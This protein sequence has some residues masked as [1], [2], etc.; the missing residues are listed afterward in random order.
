MTR[1]ASWRSV[2]LAVLLVGATLAGSVGTASAADGGP[3]THAFDME[4]STL[5]IDTGSYEGQVDIQIKSDEV[6][7]DSDIIYAGTVSTANNGNNRV[8]LV[9]GGAYDSITVIVS[10][11]PERPTFSQEGD[12]IARKAIEIGHTGGDADKQC[13]PAERTRAGLGVK[14]LDCIGYPGISSINTSSTDANQT[15]IDIYEDGLDTKTHRD[16]QLTLLENYLQD[17]Q[18]EALNIGNRAYV[19]ALRNGSSEAE[20]KTR[21]E[22]AIEDYYA[23]KQLQLR[24]SWNDSVADWAYS[25]ETAENETGISDS[26]LQVQYSPNGY[27][28]GPNITKASEMY[29]Y[30]GTM[31][32]VNGTDVPVQVFDAGGSKQAAVVPDP[33][34]ETGSDPGKYVEYFRIEAPNSEYDRLEYMNSSRYHALWTEIESQ[35][36]SVEREVNTLI[37]NSYTEYQNGEVD[38]DAFITPSLSESQYSPGDDY[39]AWAMSVLSQSGVDGPDSLDQIGSFTI[40]TN[41]TEYEG[42]LF[43]DSNPSSGRFENGATYNPAN[44]S[45]TQ[46]V[47]TEETTHILND[48]FTISEITDKD[49]NTVQNTSIET[50]TY[51]VSNLTQLQEEWDQLAQRRAEIEAREQALEANSGIPSSDGGGPD[52]QQYLLLI[53]GGAVAL[54]VVLNFA[55][56]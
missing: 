52:T 35:S 17:T 11:P 20:A 5:L 37:N 54:I 31:T 45:G 7:G 6:P 32:L 26:F 44:I 43:S 18:T 34:S 24:K 25:V 3:Y 28:P 15:E 40:Q 33:D 19:E 46:Y 23:V 4:K 21:V 48:P 9:N 56:R 22:Q 1:R 27:P 14:M 12:K 47:I 41:G 10:G 30:P 38:L 29:F 16:N 53:A 8:Y 55:N 50:V 42:I 36:E 39:Q 51:S 13:G 2:V 49:N